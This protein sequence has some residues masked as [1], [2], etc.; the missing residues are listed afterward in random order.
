MARMECPPAEET[1][2]DVRP[3]QRRSEK[4]SIGSNQPAATEAQLKEILLNTTGRVRS[5]IG[6]AGTAVLFAV[7]GAVLLCAAA[8]EQQWTFA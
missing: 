8:K 1:A 5:S 6:S 2:G 7:T 4:L 3:Q